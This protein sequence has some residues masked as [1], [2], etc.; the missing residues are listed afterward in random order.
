MNQDR[1]RNRAG[2]WAK[3]A[4][5]LTLLGVMGLGCNPLQTAAFFLHRDQK[6]PA[7]Y[8][9][10]PKDGEK[11]EKDKDLTVLIMT[12][13]SPGQQYELFAVGADKELAGRMTKHLTEAA[14]DDKQKVVVLPPTKLEVFKAQ[15]PNWKAMRPADIGKKL[16]AD[17][18][19]DVAVGPVN[20]YQPGSQN[21]IYQG[22][23]SADVAVYDTADP[24]GAAKWSYPYSFSY[25]K[26]EL[27]SV[28]RTQLPQFRM[29][30]VDNLAIELVRKHIDH[31]PGDGIAAGQ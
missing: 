1:N 20:V 11:K 15:H 16:G 22:R 30:F 4:V 24:T 26:E 25:P 12:Q 27:R 7:E 14:K 18:V 31:K 17:V 2:K 5:W 8:P 21:M 29:E 3:R 13:F 9:L 28:D 10:R 6:V 19:L 23:A